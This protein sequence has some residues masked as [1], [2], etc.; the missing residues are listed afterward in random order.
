MARRLNGVEG[1]WREGLLFPLRLSSAHSSED[2]VGHPGTLTSE[3]LWEGKE[4]IIGH[5]G[6]PEYHSLYFL[7]SYLLFLFTAVKILPF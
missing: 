4:M 2:G 5:P 7:S 3:R 1:L 6:V